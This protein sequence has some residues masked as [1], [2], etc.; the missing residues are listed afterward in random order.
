MG[1]LGKVF[2]IGKKGKIGIKVDKPFYIA[3]EL[4]TG[5]IYIHVFEPIECSAVI[6]K[7]TGKEKLKWTEVHTHT[8]SDGTIKT[9]RTSHEKETEFFKQKIVLCSVDQ[10]FAPGKYVYPFSYQLLPDLPG[11]FE[12]DEYSEGHIERLDAAIRY[13]LK[14]TLDIEGFL[15]KDL[16]AK[17]F[18]VVHERLTES[19]RPSEDST[20]Q[21]VNFL[22]CINKGTCQLGV[23][24]DKNV[25]IP[26]EA[27]QISCRIVNGS[28]VDIQAMRC[29]LF[30]DLTLR[31]NG[32]SHRFS[33][34]ISEQTFPGVPAGA[35]VDQPQPLPLVPN[36][37]RERNINPSTS[38][39][40]ISC[41]YRVDI[42][43]DIP[44]CPDVHLHM[45]V[46]LIAPMIPNVSWIPTEADGFRPS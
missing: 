16:K 35:I 11:V 30:Q 46:T 24:M 14:A 33:R 26:G 41:D 38:G 36:A 1:P 12:M 39:R 31:V 23:A 32:G 4:V 2:G 45:P 40:M 27:A 25:Y 19:I 18:L 22:C 42:E 8:D 15:A 28:Q 10:V 6:L 37:G 21:Q 3:G 5:A 43:C 13:K 29:K 7:A 9:E 17:C 20:T 44:W 34:K